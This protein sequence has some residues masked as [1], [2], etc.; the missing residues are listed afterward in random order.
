M[1]HDKFSGY[2]RNPK[3]LKKN[4]GSVDLE[5][6]SINPYEFKKGMSYELRELGILSLSEATGSDREK[7]TEAVIKNL[8]KKHSAY[9]S[10]RE[11]YDTITRNMSGRKPSFNTFLKEVDGYSMK[12]IKD[13]FKNDQM[14]E[15]KLQE[16]L[17][18]EIRGILDEILNPK[19]TKQ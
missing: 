6:E 1:S 12:E 9:Y 10:Y 19:N 13:T 14:E 5:F 15:L 8:T 7:A 3:N 4:L 16:S 11:H 18:R 17:R 2:K